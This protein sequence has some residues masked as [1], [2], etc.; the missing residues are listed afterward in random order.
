MNERIKPAI[1]KPRG[2]INKPTKE[3]ISPKSHK[4]IFTQGTQQKTRLKRAKI[5]PAVPNPFEVL[6]WTTTVVPLCGSIFGKEDC[7]C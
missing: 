1:A 3:K 5:K 7:D 6:P 4:I 2:L